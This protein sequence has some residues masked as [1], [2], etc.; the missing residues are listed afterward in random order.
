MDGMKRSQE[1]KSEKKV[2]PGRLTCVTPRIGLRGSSGDAELEK[3]RVGSVKVETLNTV[4]C[5]HT[6]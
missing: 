6:H 3:Q 1:R 2:P 4:R 5:T